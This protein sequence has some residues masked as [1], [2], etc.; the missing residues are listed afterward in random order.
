MYS[1][2][3]LTPWIVMYALAVIS[4][5]HRYLFESSERPLVR[6]E[7]E[8]EQDYVAAFSEDA[9]PGMIAEQILADIE[10]EGTYTVRLNKQNGTY[11]ITRRDPITPR[12][13]TY[14]PAEA[15]LVIERRLFTTVGFL[16]ALHRRAG[17]RHEQLMEDTWAFSVDVAIVGM[18]FWVLSG[19][20]VWWEVKMTR[21]WGLVSLLVGI[22]LFGFFLVAI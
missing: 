22:G 1:A 12:R 9:E 16:A 7:K 5:N 18:I 8:K 21:R 20:W 14:N 6:Y 13:I 17:Y 10:L 3:F 2:L 19:L 11:T 15:K 4:V